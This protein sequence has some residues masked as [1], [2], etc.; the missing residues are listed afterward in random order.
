MGGMSNRTPRRWVVKSSSWA[1]A[2]VL[3]AL[4]LLLASATAWGQAGASTIR[5][6]ITDP[7]GKLIPK[8]TV[9][10]RNESTGLT[11][12]QETTLGSFSFE[13]VPPG[14]Y[15]I[16][17]EA[18]GF[19]KAARTHVHALVGSPVDASTQL[20]VGAVAETVQVEAAASE[21]RIN[22]QDATLGNNFVN[23][24]ISQ[25]PLEARNIT[26]LLTLQ[27]GVTRDGYVA[28]ARSDQSNVTLD[29]VDI[30]DQQIEAT[31]AGQRVTNPLDTPVLR[32]NSEAI[33]EFLVTTLNP[34]A[35]QGRSSA[36]QVNLVTK[37]GTNSLHGSVFEAHRNTI[38]TANDFF[39]NRSGV[40]RP[41]LIR[42]TFGGSGGGPI[43]H[44][45]LFFFYSYEGRRDA[46]SESVVRVVPL[47]TMGLGQ[48]RV[49]AQHC[50]DP[51]KQATCGPVQT[52]TLTPTQL[53]NNVWPVVGINPAA[54][55]V[56][57]DAIKRY[58][59]NDNTQGDG[60]N[61]GGFR[62]NAL[63][64]VS[65]NSHVAKIDWI[66]NNKQTAFVRINNIYD[67]T[68]LRPQFPDTPAPTLWS[69]PW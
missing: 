1:R 56:L 51:T 64:P 61:T 40:P 2:F 9:T 55:A 24:Q 5:G 20:E 19:K 7:Q 23:Q 34:N 41:K 8:A 21:V 28:G 52:V 44:D 59:A 54:V 46:A 6:E 22:T 63:R 26:S 11:R 69:H 62:F 58:P 31:V 47:P 15:T 4:A 66:V 29:G 37:S 53:N 39:N 27:P 38:F 10:I 33:D 45:K 13:L 67:H 49:R 48:M 30:N 60:L 32:L 17:I 12:R 36:A 65:L 16:E 3:A 35:N 68:G 25:L 18:Q 57:A 42:N 14:D 50:D 43:K